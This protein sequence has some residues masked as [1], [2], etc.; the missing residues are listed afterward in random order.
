MWQSLPAEKQNELENS[1]EYIAIEE[2]LQNI[3]LGSRDDPT[4]RDQRKELC[5]QKRKLV[6]EELRKLQKL[7]PKKLSSKADKS[8]LTG[9]HCTRFLCICGLMPVRRRLASDLFSAAPI[10]SDRGRAV[11]HDMIELYRQEIEVAFCPGLEPEKCR[12]AAE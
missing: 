9:H 5:T 6:S 4:T 7:Q 10:R 1:P 3:S 2:E 12:C 11:L 8:D